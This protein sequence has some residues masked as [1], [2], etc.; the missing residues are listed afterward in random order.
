MYTSLIKALAMIVATT[1]ATELTSQ[2]QGW[3]RDGGYL[4]QGE[5]LEA[6]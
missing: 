1:E 4:V 5:R 3:S 2:T 6:G